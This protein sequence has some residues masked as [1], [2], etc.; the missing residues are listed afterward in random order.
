MKKSIFTTLALSAGLTF[1]GLSVS[2][3][4][5]AADVDYSH[6]AQAAQNNDVELNQKPIEQGNYNYSFSDGQFTYHFWNNGGNFG[7]EYHVTTPDESETSDEVR[8]NIAETGEVVQGEESIKEQTPEQKVDQQ[9]AQFDKQNKQDTATQ[10]VEQEQSIQTTETKTT[11]VNSHLQAIKQRESEG[12]YK[13][14]NPS[15]GASGAYQIL[16]STWSAY[17]PSEYQGMSAADAPKSVQD[18]V[19]QKIYDKAGPSQWVTA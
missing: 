16:D 14:V 11:S 3:D 4:A 13:A 12:D 9:Q 1:G 10:A 19:A 6:L 17:A 7:Y 2:D 8:Q 18:E 5:K 15:S